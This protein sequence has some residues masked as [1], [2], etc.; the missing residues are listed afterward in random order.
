MGFFSVNNWGLLRTKGLAGF[1]DAD[2]DYGN[3]LPVCSPESL[4]LMKLWAGLKILFK[5]K[6]FL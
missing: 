4:L 3:L 2:L 5:N 1:C 6:V